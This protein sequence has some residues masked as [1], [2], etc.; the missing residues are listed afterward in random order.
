MKSYY[1]YLNHI[2]KSIKVVIDNLSGKFKDDAC[3]YVYIWPLQQIY[4][5]T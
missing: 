1:L 5:T 4:S 2:V 3:K